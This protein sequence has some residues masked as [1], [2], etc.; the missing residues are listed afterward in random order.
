[1]SF[2]VALYVPDGIVM[3]ADSRL[4]FTQTRTLNDGSQT[5][6]AVGIS[7]YSA[8]S[9][10]TP[11]GV[12]ICT[13]GAA[14]I[15]GNPIGGVLT[16]FILDETDENTN[17]DDVARRLLEYVRDAHSELPT[18]F[19]VGGY[20][21]GEDGK[22]APR[23]WDLY[24]AN[25]YIKQT[26]VPGH[27]GLSWRGVSDVLA[28]LI[29]PLYVKSGDDY[30]ALPQFQIQWSAMPLGEAVDFAAYA[31][32]STVELMRFQPRGRTVGG[33]VELMVITPEGSRW[34]NRKKLRVSGDHYRPFERNM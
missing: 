30:T 34:I 18:G 25:N 13:Y 5:H 22:P 10:L 27:H 6:T 23:I 1:M 15:H 19:L 20:I 7:D 21:D 28:R 11:S 33:E 24:V 31:V 29:Q 32:E 26:C 14:D 16:E 2:L 17:V 8:K 3:A 12:G 9:F 4:T